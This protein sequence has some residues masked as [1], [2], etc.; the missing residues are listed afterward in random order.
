MH[1]IL[2]NLFFFLLALLDDSC[3]TYPLLRTK[4]EE[5]RSLALYIN[6]PDYLLSP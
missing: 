4:I 6:I 2:M 5:E 3:T 1:K